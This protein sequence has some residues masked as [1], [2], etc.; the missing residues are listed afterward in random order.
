[1]LLYALFF[2]PGPLEA[3]DGPP[4]LAAS[5]A[6]PDTVCTLSTEAE[7]YSQR[8]TRAYDDAGRLVSRRVSGPVETDTRYTWSENAV[9][10]VDY[11][12][13][14]GGLPFQTYQ[15]DLR[16]DYRGRARTP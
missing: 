6:P 2:P 8:E 13:T 4:G 5:R 14:R 11:V 1:M 3:V 15:M 10:R 16:V 9:V 12:H 7:H